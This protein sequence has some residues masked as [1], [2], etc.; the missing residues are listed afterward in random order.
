MIDLI[1]ALLE[2][3]GNKLWILISLLLISSASLFLFTFN[4]PLSFKLYT[5]TIKDETYLLHESSYRVKSVV[6]TNG[7]ASVHL[8]ITE[9]TKTLKN[10]L[11]EQ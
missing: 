1:K 2:F 3:I 8:C 9:K 7:G 10:N 4:H 5:C 6:E 11:V